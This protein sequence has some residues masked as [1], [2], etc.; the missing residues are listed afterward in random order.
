MNFT[1]FFKDSTIMGDKFRKATYILRKSE[2]KKKI[3][4]LNTAYNF[5]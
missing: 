4:C 5:G 2:G 1:R 3:F